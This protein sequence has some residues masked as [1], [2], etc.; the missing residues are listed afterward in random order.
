MKTGQKR[1]DRGCGYCARCDR[2]WENYM[3]NTDILILLD[4]LETEIPFCGC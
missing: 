4:L 2:G 3:R 1:Q